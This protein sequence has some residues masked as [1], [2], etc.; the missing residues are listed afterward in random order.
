MARRQSMHEP[1]SDSVFPLPNPLL[2]A[3]FGEPAHGN[4]FMGYALSQSPKYVSM[5]IAICLEFDAHWR[6]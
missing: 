1:T 5:P 6:S 2:Q 3:A 4:R